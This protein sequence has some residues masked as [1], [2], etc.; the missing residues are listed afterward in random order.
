MLDRVLTQGQ[1]PPFDPRRAV[2]R[3]VSV[4]REFGLHAVS[5]DKYAGETFVSDFQRESISY[6][7]VDRSASELYEALEPVLNAHRVILLDEP[8]LEQQ[9]LGLVWRGGK[10]THQSC[11]HDDVAN[12]VAG[13]VALA[14]TTSDGRTAAA[15]LSLNSEAR[16]TPFPQ[17]AGVSGSFGGGLDLDRLKRALGR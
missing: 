11:E 9:L 15:V 3:F 13:A 16:S 1:A 10:I 5:G 4:L 8:M 2:A 14:D 17:P 6:R 12:A 7:V